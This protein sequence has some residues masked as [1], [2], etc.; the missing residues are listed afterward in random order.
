[1]VSLLLFLNF[2]LTWGYD[3]IWWMCNIHHLGM[4]LFMTFCPIIEWVCGTTLRVPPLPYI[5]IYTC[6]YYLHLLKACFFYHGIQSPF[7]SSAFGRNISIGTSLQIYVCFFLGGSCGKSP[8]SLGFGYLKI[9]W[10][11]A[12]W[13]KAAIVGFFLRFNHHLEPLPLLVI[14]AR[15]YCW[16]KNSCTS[17]YG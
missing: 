9:W 8:T 16:L 13:S 7:N 2:I 11:T 1:M 4:F 12:W 5:C 14:T 17:W 6:F 15:W 10:P 3:P